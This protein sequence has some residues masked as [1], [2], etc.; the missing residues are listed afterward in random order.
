MQPPQAYKGSSHA[1]T[2]IEA[3]LPSVTNP[4]N[5]EAD[6]K[7]SPTVTATSPDTAKEKR[8]RRQQRLCGIFGS[9]GSALYIVMLIFGFG[10]LLWGVGHKG[11]G[12][13]VVGVLTDAVLLG[14]R[15]VAAVR[16]DGGFLGWG[17]KFN[18]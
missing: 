13:D 5:T 4:A 16:E 12:E 8:K 18:V 10:L 11:A 14:G 15:V 9:F 7:L 17:C 1:I 3:H 2:D 6:A